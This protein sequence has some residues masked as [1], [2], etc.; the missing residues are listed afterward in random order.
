MSVYAAAY[1]TI[2]HQV[3]STGRQLRGIDHIELGLMLKDIFA[4]EEGASGVLDDKELEMLARFMIKRVDTTGTGTFSYDNFV[5]TCSQQEPMDMSLIARL[6]DMDRK[7]SFLERLLSEKPVFVRGA[8][9][10]RSE[11]S[12]ID[13][14][15]GPAIPTNPVAIE[16]R[17]DQLHE[18]ED[19]LEQKLE[20]AEETQEVEYSELRKQISDRNAY[21]E[22]QLAGLQ[23]NFEE[24]K[25][26]LSSQFEVQARLVSSQ[27]EQQAGLISS[28]LEQ[29]AGKF[30][31]LASELKAG[32][33]PAASS[34]WFSDLFQTQGERQD[35]QQAR[36]QFEALE[37]RLQARVQALELQ[38]PLGAGG[39]ERWEGKDA[40]SSSLDNNLLPVGLENLVEKVNSVS[41]RVDSVCN[42]VADCVIDLTELKGRFRYLDA[43]VG[44]LSDAFRSANREHSQLATF[45]TP[46]TR[47]IAMPNLNT[48]QTHLSSI[49]RTNQPSTVSDTVNASME[50]L[51]GAYV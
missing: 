2:T 4:S 25:A 12:L 49:S 23:A 22:E 35:F 37:A 31:Q 42:K 16:E 11:T 8:H 9:P 20:E 26:K 33:E 40:A 14:D 21:F 50:P 43:S 1:R 30:S 38:I 36:I 34:T 3:G 10:L 45:H 32:N 13:M 41:G 48:S 18:Q 44:D 24:L 29:Q 6:F 17:L 19:E 7:P 27:F 39:N 15:D 46:L 28:Q 5:R 47:L 51:A